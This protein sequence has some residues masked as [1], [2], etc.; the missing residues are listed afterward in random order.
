VRADHPL[1]G[2]KR[3]LIECLT[4]TREAKPTHE[5]FMRNRMLETIEVTFPYTHE[6]VFSTLE[7]AI[8]FSI[9][10][11]KA[12]Q[13]IDPILY[14]GQKICFAGWRDD[15]I[16]LQLENGK[17]LHFQY[18]ERS[19]ELTIDG[20]LPGDVANGSRAQEVVLSFPTGHQY[21]WKK[22]SLIKSLQ[23]N[24]IRRISAAQEG[25]FLY[26]ISVDIL[27]IDFVMERDTQRTL[28]YWELTQ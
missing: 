9:S 11:D 25:F 16:F 26:V 23:G 17:V 21:L 28:L 3:S 2:F 19:V 13:T 14:V 7:K 6:P 15:A 8:A 20:E 22:D 12:R 5:R 4:R 18:T 24:A 27:W 1:A 10:I